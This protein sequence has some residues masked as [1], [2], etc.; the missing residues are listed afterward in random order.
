LRNLRSLQV[1]CS[2]LKKPK[3]LYSNEYCFCYKVSIKD[4]K[5]ENKR[6]VSSLDTLYS[7]FISV[8]YYSLM[9]FE[10]TGHHRHLFVVNTIESAVSI[11]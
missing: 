4:E 5:K 1:Y 6:T 8:Q 11:Y 2:G 9:K 10:T 3:I 7:R